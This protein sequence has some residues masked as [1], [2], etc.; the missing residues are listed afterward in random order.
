MNAA[1]ANPDQPGSASCQ[2][3]QGPVLPLTEVRLIAMCC[4]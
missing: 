1:I 3:V 2:L 4:W